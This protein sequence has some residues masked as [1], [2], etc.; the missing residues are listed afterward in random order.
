VSGI[1][2]VETDLCLAIITTFLIALLLRRTL[3]GACSQDIN[4][5]HRQ[6]KRQAKAPLLPDGTDY[7]R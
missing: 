5:L 4:A 2:V 7:P 1:G 6:V 3:G